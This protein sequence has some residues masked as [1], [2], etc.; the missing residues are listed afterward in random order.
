MR[1]KKREIKRL[2]EIERERVRGRKR[3]ISTSEVCGLFTL[4]WS[5]NQIQSGFPALILL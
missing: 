2:K 1:E 4:L 5:I 3:K